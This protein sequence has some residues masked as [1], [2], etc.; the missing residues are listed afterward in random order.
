MSGVFYHFLG[1]FQG[2]FWGFLHNR[3][4]TLV[5]IGEQ[6]IRTKSDF[7]KECL[8]SPITQD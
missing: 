6:K 1:F 3:V 5:T 2:K 7:F 4:A 8:P